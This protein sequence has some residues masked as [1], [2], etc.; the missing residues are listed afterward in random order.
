MGI[1]VLSLFDGLSCGQIALNR[2]GIKIDNYFASEIDK[3]SIQITRK[4]Y[5]N[6]IQ[7]GNIYDINYSD[8]PRID[9]I[10]GGSPCTYWS[11][12]KKGRETTSEGI[13]FDLFMQYVNAVKKYKD[14]Y[15]VYENNFSMHKN[16]KLEIT[17]KLGVEPVLINSAKLSAQNRKRLYWTNI[18]NVTQPLNKNISLKDIVFDDALFVG[19][20]VGRRLDENGTRKDYSDIPIEQRLEIRENSKSGTI[21][22]VAKDN[23]ILTKEGFAICLHNLY[24]GFGET[25]NRVFLDKS[26]TIRTPAGGGHIPSVLIEETALNYFNGSKQELIDFFK[27]VPYKQLKEWNCIRYLHPVECE[28]LQTIDVNYTEGVSNSQRY[29]MIGNGFTVDVIGH[30]LK[31]II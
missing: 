5:P 24:G 23:T 15:F 13:G 9:L 26:P 14:A 6:T 4:N 16:I 20:T 22:T 31:G 12:A 25:K 29:K 30:I 17:E 21:T 27:K 28:K 8:L 11:I 19:R 10:L 2:L 18:P 3:Y 7:L 1:N